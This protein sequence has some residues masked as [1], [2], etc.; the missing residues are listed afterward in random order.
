MNHGLIYKKSVNNFLLEGFID[1]DYAG[2]KDNRKSTSAYFFL[3]NGNC[4][5]WKVQQQPVVALSTTEAEFMAATEGIKEA[6]WLQGLLKE[7]KFLNNKPVLYLDNQSA[8]FLCKNPVY[9]DR[10]KHIEIKY[11]Y[12]RDK[13]SEGE[14]EL[15]KV[16]TE[17]NPADCGT[18]VVT[19]AKFEHCLELL[20]IGE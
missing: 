1:S 7:L 18:K 9:H 20:Q 5:S 4:I 6:T 11:F 17:H 2:N 19:S 13:I 12:I 8:I 16:P 10:S 14:I 3:L 15:E